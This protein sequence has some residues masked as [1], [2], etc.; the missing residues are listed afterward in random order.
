M[1]AQRRRVCNSDALRRSEW[2]KRGLWLNVVLGAVESSLIGG[3]RAR[4]IEEVP[5]AVR[6]RYNGRVFNL[7][8][9]KQSRP[10]VESHRFTSKG[11]KRFT[12]GSMDDS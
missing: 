8:S 12:R 2:S 4:V 10:S 9:I 1:T 3:R 6:Q 7:H 5:L 11:A